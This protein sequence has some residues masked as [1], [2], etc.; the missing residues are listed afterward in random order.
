V[1]EPEFRYEREAAATLDRLRAE[2][3]DRLWG[4]ICDA[5]DTIID[6]PDSRDA[7]AEELRGRDGK[8]VWKVD[9]FDRAGDY[10]LLW[11]HDE[12]GV[13]VIAWIG[14]WPPG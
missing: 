5:L 6:R 10:A 1:T 11:H 8:A 7:R 2:A 12:H 14:L 9:V 3:S 13:I 4:K